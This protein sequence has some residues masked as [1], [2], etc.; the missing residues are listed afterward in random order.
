ME[1][2]MYIEGNSF[3]SSAD[4][5]MKRFVGDNDIKLTSANTKSEFS[6]LTNLNEQGLIDLS[7]WKGEVVMTWSMT[8]AESVTSKVNKNYKITKTD[9]KGFPLMLNYN[10]E[11]K[12]K[13]KSSKTNWKGIAD[14]FK[15]YDNLYNEKLSAPKVTTNSF[16][17]QKSQNWPCKYTFDAKGNWITAEIGSIKITREIKY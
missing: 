16:E 12:A 7:E 5:I 14:R 15:S 8:G 17:V 1:G 9:E 4:P 3:F 2:R 10:Y 11:N 13:F 6:V